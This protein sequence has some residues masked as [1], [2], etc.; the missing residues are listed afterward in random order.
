MSRSDDTQAR[1]PGFRLQ[2][3]KAALDSAA[4]DTSDAA[5]RWG[6]LVAAVAID[7][8]DFATAGPIGLATGVFVGG[9]LTAVVALANG[10]PTRRA[11]ALAALGGIY[12]ALPLTEALPLATLLM[13]LHGLVG[14]SAKAA[15]PEPQPAYATA[16]VTQTGPGRR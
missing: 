5:V 3:T 13:L 6:P 14:R 15:L 1:R 16:R 9:L 12:C 8:A 4:A 10:A 7:V 2:R 11:L